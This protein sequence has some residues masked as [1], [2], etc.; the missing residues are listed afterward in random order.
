MQ[1]SSDEHN[2]AWILEAPLMKSLPAR[3]LILYLLRIL[4]VSL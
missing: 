1:I 4:H 2:I 3:Y